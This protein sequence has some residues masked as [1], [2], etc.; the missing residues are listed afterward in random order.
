M[1]RRFWIEKLADEVVERFPNQLVYHTENGIGAS[2]F[3]H[4]GSISDAVRSY[5]IKLALEERGLKAEHIAFSDDKDGLRKVPQG[6]PEELKKYIG[7]PVTSVPD[8]FRCHSSYGEHMGWLLLDALDRLGITYKFYSG[9]DV[10][11]RGLLNEQIRVILS[12][13][14]KVGEIIQQVSGQTKYTRTL[15]YLPVCEKCGRIYTTEATG[16][17]DSSF[18]VT[19]TCVGGD[20]GGRWYEGCGHSGVRKIADGEGKLVW[21]AEFAA[22]WAALDVSFEAYGKELTDSVMINDRI[23]GEVLGK[24][25]PVHTRYELF[26]SKG[27]RKLSKSS[28]E[29]V[30][31]DEWLKYGS[32]ASLRLLMYKRFEGAR[33]IGIEDVPVYMDELDA[34]EEVYFGIKKVDDEA[35]RLDKVNLYRYAHLLRVPTKPTPHPPY[36]LLV[37]LAKVAPQNGA[38]EYILE[39]LRA[40]GYT[41]RDEFDRRALLEKAGYAMNWAKD[42]A[43]ISASSQLADDEK[44]IVM[45]VA[46]KLAEKN[47]E[48]G[49]QQCV[50]EASAEL[51][52]DSKRV[53]QALY[54]ALLGQTSGPR[55]GSYV[56]AMGKE[57]VI[58][59]LLEAAK[60]NE[61]SG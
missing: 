33:E 20:I 49:F 7:V 6:L 8:P 45:R 15:P 37:Y 50:Y 56:K 55:F 30:T 44:P 5:G 11:R 57:E 10:Y 17:D 59:R 27:G 29:L 48:A 24:R 61:A 25:P 54:R 22:R 46:Q 39:K 23:C 52:I 51:G 40:Y 13:W 53:F 18:S 3:P 14:K 60:S 58:R 2:G 32:P 4:I 34:L 38:A 12:N 36:N 21:K 16:Y 41:P 42:Y 9:A 19:Y 43:E 35:E 1:E 31:A 26:L 28:G 47:D